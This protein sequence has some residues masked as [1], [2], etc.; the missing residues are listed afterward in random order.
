[1]VSALGSSLYFT[2]RSTD[3]DPLSFRPNPQN[4]VNPADGAE[5]GGKKD[6]APPTDGIY[7]PPRVAP[8]PYTSKSK[9]QLRKERPPVPSALS[10]LLTDPSI[11]H[12][13]STSGLG[14]GNPSLT[15]GRAAYLKRITEFEEDN[16]QRVT[17]KKSEARRRARDE[18]DLALGASL[19]SGG[20]GRR[21]RAGGLEDEFGDVLRSVERGARG[22]GGVVR[23]DGYDE[24]RNRS[25]KGTVLD[26]SRKREVEPGEDG[27]TRTRKRSRFELDRK[28]RK[29]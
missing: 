15:S 11:P 28:R 2:K 19:A 3:L 12:T 16:F 18:E 8:V 20:N 9:S 10:A 7:R 22:T 5:P 25:K 1:M 21:R 14:S 13:E 6:N 27:E 17:M 23:G 26:R 4:L 29:N 24:L